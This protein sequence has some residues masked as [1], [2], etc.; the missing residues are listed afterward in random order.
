MLSTQMIKL[1]ENSQWKVNN[2]EQT[3]FGDFN[4]YLFTGLEGKGFKAF[5]TSVAG[6]AP[7]ALQTLRKF[8]DSNFKALKLRNYE[9]NDNFLCVRMQEGLIPLSSEKMEYLLAQIS[10]LLSL[11]DLPTDACAVCGQPAKR[12]GLYYGLFCHLH[13]EC[14][15]LEPVDFTKITTSEAETDNKND[16]GPDEIEIEDASEQETDG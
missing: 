12:K 15:D 5:I 8:L 13:A 14:Q 6:I 1:A 2:E 4:G 11:G 16:T 7:E 9:V 3:V 10:G